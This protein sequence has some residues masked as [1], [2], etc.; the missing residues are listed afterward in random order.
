MKLARFLAEVRT[1]IRTPMLGD[2]DPVGMIFSQLAANGHT[3]EARALRK[4]ALAVIDTYADVTDADLWALG[5]DALGL[6][7]AF[8]AYRF[9]GLYK[10]VELDIMA[11]RLR[12]EAP[13]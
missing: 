7:D 3:V 8:A 10:Q 1:R 2:L 13:A 5:K 11:R 6:L 9:T 4:A 12:A